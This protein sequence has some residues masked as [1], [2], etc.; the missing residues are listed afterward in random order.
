MSVQLPRPGPVQLALLAASAALPAVLIVVAALPAVQE[1]LAA[2]LS[3][4]AVEQPVPARLGLP[5]VAE[6]VA[7]AVVQFEAA[8]SVMAAELAPM[9]VS[10]MAAEFVVMVLQVLAEQREPE[11]AVQSELESVLELVEQAEQVPAPELAAQRESDP[12]TLAGQLAMALLSVAPVVVS[13]SASVGVLRECAVETEAS[14][15]ADRAFPLPSSAQ[16]AG[17]PLLQPSY[18]V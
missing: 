5:V 18:L 3:V 16:K 12:P 2:L 1:E 6:F 11:L 8:V 7:V 17:R 9:A 13:V 14:Q 15:T 4:Q 10:V